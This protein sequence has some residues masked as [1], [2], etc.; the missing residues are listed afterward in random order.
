MKLWRGRDD[1]RLAVRDGHNGL[2]LHE[3]EQLLELTRH[4]GDQLR[5][6]RVTRFQSV[7]GFPGIPIAQAAR[8]APELLLSLPQLS[9]GD[10]KQAV[11]GKRDAL[12]EAQF[13]LEPLTAEPER[14][15]TFRGQIV[16]KIVHIASDRCGGL[17]GGVREIPEHVEI[18]ERG[19]CL[20]QIF[21]DEVQRAFERFSADF[22]EDPRRILDVL[23]CR[24][25]E[26]RRLAQFRQHASGAFFDRRVLEHDL[27]CEARGQCIGVALRVELPG[28]DFLDVENAATN[29]LSQ[30]PLLDLLDWCQS[31]RPDG[32]Q[33]PP[34]AGQLASVRLQ[35]ESSQII[36]KVVVGM[37]AI[38]GGVGRLRLVQ[39]RQVVADKMRQGLSRI[40]RD[41]RGSDYMLQRLRM[42]Q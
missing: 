28:P 40:H 41:V 16:S 12:I 5:I 18:I 21:L 24:L 11:G 10:R 22:D 20:G 17:V 23:T 39:V 1:Q 27:S 13:L 35:R 19:K 26:P 25:D 32:V 37:Y 15:A 8:D 6:G 4:H 9:H 7:P 30:H 38:E 29:V 36:E 34:E 3:G 14:S 33:P 42:V 31:P 2:A